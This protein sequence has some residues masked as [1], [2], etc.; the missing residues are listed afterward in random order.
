M[1]ISSILLVTLHLLG[2]P[3]E[4]DSIKPRNLKE[5][6]IYDNNRRSEIGKLPEVYGTLIYAGK[7]TSQ[8]TIGDVQGN[9]ANNSGRQILAKVPGLHIWESDASNLQLGIA[10]RGLSPN[11]SW[12]FNIRQNGYDI[13]ADPFGYPEAYYTPPMQAV[14]SI[15]FVR[16]QGALQYGP[17][18]GGMV[19]FKLRNGSD[20]TKKIQAETQQTVGSYGMISSY[21][22][23]G[24]KQGKVNYYAFFDYRSGKGWRENSLYNGQTGFGTLTWNPTEKLEISFDVLRYT[25]VSQQA[26]GLTDAQFNE[27]PRQSFR[28][29][30]WMNVGWTTVGMHAKYSVSATQRIEVIA[31]GVAGD[32]NSI[33]FMPSGGITVADTINETLGTYNPRTI[34][35]DLYRNLSIESRYLGDYKA[36]NNTWTISAG[37]RYFRGNTTRNR[38][39]KGTTGSDFDLTRNGGWNSDIDLNTNNWAAF[40]ENIFRIGEKLMIIPGVRFETVSTSANGYNGITN[41]VPQAIQDVEL[42]RSFLLSGIGFEYHLTEK[43]E[44]YANIS[45]AYRPMLFSDLTA[46]PANDVIDPDLK[47]AKGWNADVGYRGTIKD[48]LFFDFSVYALQYDNRIGTIKQQRADGSFYNYRTN[49]A[50]SRTYGTEALVEFHPMKISDKQQKF[51]ASTFISWS[52]CDAMYDDYKAIVQSGTSLVETNNKDKKVEYAPMQ[53]IRS[54]VTVSYSDLSLTIQ[55]SYTGETFSDATNTEAPTANGQNGKIPS[56]Q[57]MDLTLN[58]VYEEKL[59]LR[60]GINNLNNEKYFTRRSGGYPGPGLLPAEGRTF[61][62]GMSY[63]F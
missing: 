14:K 33:G 7:K 16:G 6:N 32:R 4:G 52:Y 58:Y 23:I 46:S 30:N 15:E 21:T 31:S 25:T 8:I 2:G 43:T 55:H 47:D 38:G 9:T 22:A 54:G 57:V 29:R 41:N 59:G 20:F 28:E 51:D 19:N 63:K 18:F 5:V 42:N 34:D 37:L 26:G 49:I 3:T 39:G 27:N 36:F 24:G 50:N 1:P 61:F 60:A 45:Q 17:Q 56:Y 53:I 11:R 48:Y 62:V 13:A 10:A 12:E 35:R 44:F 40:A